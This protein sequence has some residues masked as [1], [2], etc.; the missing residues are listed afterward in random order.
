[1]APLRCITFEITGTLVCMSL[2]LGQVYNDALRHYKLPCPSDDAMKAAF[3]RAYKSTG[4]ALPNYG[5]AE[6]MPERSWWDCMIKSTLT[7]A[8]CS[9]ALEPE[10]FPLVFQRL[11]SSFG[12]AAVWQARPDGVLAMR[13]AKERGLVVGA[14]SNVYPRYVDQN[15]PLLGLH[16]DLDFAATSYELGVKKPDPALFDAARRRASHA[17]RLLYGPE[18]PELQFDEMLHV[19]DDVVNDYEAA[20]ALGMRAL[21]YDPKG[22][23]SPADVPASAVVRSLSEVPGKLDALT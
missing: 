14:L 5:A 4:A 17:A 22:A 10:T 8:G 9:E 3:K 23:A 19:G 1:M 2:P 20:T 21:L 16:H 7:E 12:S 13:H 18:Q 15:L 11:Y 6:G